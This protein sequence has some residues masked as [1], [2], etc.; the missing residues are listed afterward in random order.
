MLIQF[1]SDNDH[2]RG[3]YYLL[4]S[5]LTSIGAIIIVLF[6]LIFRKNRMRKKTLKQKVKEALREKRKRQ[7]LLKSSTLNRANSAS[8]IKLKFMKS[9][10]S[11][12]KDHDESSFVSSKNQTNDI[13]KLRTPDHLKLHKLEDLPNNNKK[14]SIISPTHKCELKEINNQNNQNNYSC[15]IGDIM[16]HSPK[17]IFNNSF[18]S[19]LVV[20]NVKNQFPNTISSLN[21][22]KNT[23]NENSASKTDVVGDQISEISFQHMPTVKLTEKLD[24][25]VSSI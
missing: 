12:I 9:S 13:L 25:T 24:V 6:I 21:N 1:M 4:I 20:P 10:C 15:V 3:S 11:K 23:K 8:S 17:K 22:L 5:L 18:L 14:D 16:N 19:S 7:Y 2:N